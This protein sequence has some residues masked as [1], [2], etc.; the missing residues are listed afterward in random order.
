MSFQEDEAKVFNCGLFEGTLLRFEVEMVFTE[1]VKDLYYDLMMLFFSL[2]AKDED[3]VHIDDDYPLVNEFFEE[4]IHHHM[5]GGGTVCQAKEHHQGLKEASVHPEG[6]FPLVSLFNMHVVVSPTDVQ[7][8]E[9]L[10]IGFRDLVKDV[11]DQR[12]GVGILHCHC[13]ELLVVLD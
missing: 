4:V 3:V 9:V 7:L 6:S 8:C 5:E 10:G 12:E 2:T 13:I 1:D 11:W